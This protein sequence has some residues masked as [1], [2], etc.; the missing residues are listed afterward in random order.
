MSL[1]RFHGWEPTR[2][3]TY[4]YDDDGRLLRSMETVE[5][6]WDEDER[7]WVTALR[8]YRDSLC[9]SCGGPVEEC[10]APIT[11]DELRR[12]RFIVEHSVCARTRELRKAMKEAQE[13]AEEPAALVFTTRRREGAND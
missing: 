13:T 11:F 8:L 2:T 9:P 12:G 3:T 10:H 4:E 7:A 6:E 1:K 5:P